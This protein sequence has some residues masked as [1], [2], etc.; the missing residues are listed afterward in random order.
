MTDV[1]AINARFI[2]GIIKFQMPAW[3]T[4]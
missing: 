2:T 3:S 1:A 4:I